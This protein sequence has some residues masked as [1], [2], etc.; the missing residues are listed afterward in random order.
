[1]I[2]NQIYFLNNFNLYN[3]NIAVF[4]FQEAHQVVAAALPEVMAHQVVAD[5]VSDL[6]II[7]KKI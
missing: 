3:L 4:I 6:W 5:T 2:S 1:M 7:N